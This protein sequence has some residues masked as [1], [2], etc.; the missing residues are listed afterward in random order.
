M[1]DAELNVMENTTFSDAMSFCDKA[2][3][4]T[5]WTL[6]ERSKHDE[7]ADLVDSDFVIPDLTCKN[8]RTL[9]WDMPVLVTSRSV[10]PVDMPASTQEATKPGT[11]HLTIREEEYF[12][13]LNA[14]H[15]C[16]NPNILFNYDLHGIHLRDERCLQ[17]VGETY[18][19]VNHPSHYRV[20]EERL[21][22]HFEII[23]DAKH[24]ARQVLVK[25]D[26]TRHTYK[27]TETFPPVESL[28]L[29]REHTNIVLPSIRK[30]SQSSKT[31]SSTK[32]TSESI[33]KLYTKAHKVLKHLLPYQ[34]PP[35]D[36]KLPRL[37]QYSECGT[38][39]AVSSTTSPSSL[40]SRTSVVNETLPKIV[41][42]EPTKNVRKPRK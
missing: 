32:S 42:P 21:N 20:L 9:R 23:E 35:S 19:C 31:Q 5:Y 17:I 13:S 41:Q 37:Y 10:R 34:Q 1:T 7:L 29:P 24:R 2:S 18:Y 40:S 14:I 22:E 4:A 8:Y 36:I 33:P 39:S 38:F 28:R 30:S 25:P 12:R 16:H 26:K 11:K 3:I 27:L 15:F 6:R